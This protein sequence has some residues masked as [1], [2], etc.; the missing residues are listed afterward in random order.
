MSVQFM[1]ARCDFHLV[2]K[3]LFSIFVV[4]MFLIFNLLFHSTF[5]ALSPSHSQ[6]LCL[7]CIS[8]LFLFIVDNL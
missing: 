7:C 1:N 4:L 5:S 2:V 3:F 8:F 6:L